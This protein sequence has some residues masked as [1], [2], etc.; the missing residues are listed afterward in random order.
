VNLGASNTG[1]DANPIGCPVV[2]SNSRILAK[3]VGCNESKYTP[4]FPEYWIVALVI[5]SPYL[6]KK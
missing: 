4:P 6:D 1:D 5:S 3:E 2:F